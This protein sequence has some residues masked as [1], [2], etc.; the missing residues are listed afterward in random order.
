[1][2][3][4]VYV[5]LIIPADIENCTVKPVTC[6]NS[7]QNIA[8]N[9]TKTFIFQKIIWHFVGNLYGICQYKMKALVSG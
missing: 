5:K 2:K 6:Y 9:V 1:M 7:L 4:L 8:L 3:Y